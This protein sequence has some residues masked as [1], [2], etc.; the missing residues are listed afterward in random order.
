MFDTE[1]RQQSRV[2][3]HTATGN[4]PVRPTAQQPSSHETTG[5]LVETGHTAVDC[6]GALTA[7]AGVD[8]DPGPRQTTTT[9]QLDL[10]ADTRSD[11]ITWT[12]TPRRVKDTKGRCP[13]RLK[14]ARKL[15]IVAGLAR[16]VWMSA[17][18]VVR[19]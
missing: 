8:D 7:R 1:F 10:D 9:R 4:T 15:T 17:A 13:V 19:I 18:E 5:R 3:L 14:V 2:G 12:P 6:H 16:L 11:I